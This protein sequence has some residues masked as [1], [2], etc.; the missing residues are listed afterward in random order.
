MLEQ[1]LFLLRGYM[2]GPWHKPTFTCSS[3]STCRDALFRDTNAW[4]LTLLPAL[5]KKHT[6]IKGWNES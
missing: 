3:L 5:E 4:L 6:V 2:A 1:L